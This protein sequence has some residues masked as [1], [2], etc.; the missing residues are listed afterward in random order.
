[1]PAVS[2]PP[3]S[4]ASNARKRPL[5]NLT[6]KTKPAPQRSRLLFY[7]QPD[8][9]Q[10]M[11]KEN[12]VDAK[13]FSAGLHTVDGLDYS[14]NSVKALDEEGIVLKGKSKQ[15]TE[16][17]LSQMDYVFG[18]TSFIGSEIILTFPEH[19]DKVYRFP[20]EVSDP[21]GGDIGMYKICFANITAGI[22]KIISAINSGEI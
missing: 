3:P 16:D 21:F 5:S 12:N 4:M 7:E 22:E 1:M 8:G 11:A 13:A 17:M 9:D 15:L 14:D 18:M 20:V 2:C 6:N 10:N 19:A